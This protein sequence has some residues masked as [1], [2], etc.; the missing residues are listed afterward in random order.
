MNNYGSY[1]TYGSLND[2]KKKRR[3]LTSRQKVIIVVAIMLLAVGATAFFTFRNGG[4]IT[5]GS[6]KTAASENSD[7]KSEPLRTMCYTDT[8]RRYGYDVLYAQKNLRIMLKESVIQTADPVITFEIINDSKKDMNVQLACC[9]IDNMWFDMSMDCTVKSHETAVDSITTHNDNFVQYPIEVV[10]LCFKVTNLADNSVTYSD[11]ISLTYRKYTKEPN[12]SITGNTTTRLEA[13][14]FE[15]L[16][17]AFNFENDGDKSVMDNTMYIRNSSSDDIKYRIEEP[18]LFDADGNRIAEEDYTIDYE[19]VVPGLSLYDR[20][21]TLTLTKEPERI[22]KI[23]YIR[24][25]FVYEYIND[26]NERGEIK[27]DIVISH[28]VESSEGE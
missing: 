21:L 27:E 18:A 15:V 5:E 6:P 22:S 28:S 8:K 24:F 7:V 20:S 10:R 16:S 23:R 25:K 2:K 26:P 12:W 17:G 14:D 3:Q 4:S 11:P 1:G 9:S 19:G 13:D